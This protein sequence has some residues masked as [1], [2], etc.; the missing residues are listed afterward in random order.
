[1]GNSQS[2]FRQISNKRNEVK[3]TVKFFSVTP[4]LEFARAV[5]QKSPDAVIQAIFNAAVNA[6]QGAVAVPPKLKPLFRHHNH[7]FDFL[8]DRKTPIASKRR[9]ILQK[10]GALPIIVPLL[11]CSWVNRWGIY[12]AAISQK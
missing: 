4:D 2:K 12:F 8:I 3:R 6:R 5:L 7:H 11:T 1:M 10:G 9:L